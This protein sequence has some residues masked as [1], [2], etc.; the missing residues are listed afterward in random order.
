MVSWQKQHTNSPITERLDWRLVGGGDD[1][2]LLSF[3]FPQIFLRLFFVRA[4]ILELY[5]A[6]QLFMMFRLVEFDG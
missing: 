4:S 1:S 6:V 5:F 2:G 3:S